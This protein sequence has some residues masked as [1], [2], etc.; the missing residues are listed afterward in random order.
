VKLIALDG[1]TYNMR[2]MMEGV[3][4]I[5][6]GAGSLVFAGAAQD[7]VMP[8]RPDAL[9]ALAAAGGPLDLR[10]RHAIVSVQRVLVMPL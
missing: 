9:Q 10:L 1:S 8:S 6:P 7:E 2:A 4:L 5:M 3:T